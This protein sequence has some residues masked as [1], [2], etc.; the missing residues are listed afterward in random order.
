MKILDW[1]EESRFSAF[2]V[3]FKQNYK[4][5]LF[6]WIMTLDILIILDWKRSN[7]L[8]VY[9]D[10]HEMHLEMISCVIWSL[11]K[12]FVSHK[13]L[14]LLDVVSIQVIPHIINLTHALH[15]KWSIPL[16]ISTVNMTAGNWG[17]SHIYWRTP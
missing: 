9:F 15:K 16:R 7:K 3:N 13:I 14:I 12:L 1:L 11:M 17:F 8:N 2:T 10:I 5:V 6:C 4:L